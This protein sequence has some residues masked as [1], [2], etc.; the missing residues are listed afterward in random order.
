MTMCIHPTYTY[1]EWVQ[2]PGPDMRQ[3]QQSPG[4]AKGPGLWPGPK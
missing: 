2:A 1:L 4:R 3:S